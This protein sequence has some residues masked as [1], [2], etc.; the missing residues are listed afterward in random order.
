M[1]RVIMR[2][3]YVV[4]EVCILKDFLEKNMTDISK[5]KRK[6]LLTNGVIEVNGKVQTKYNYPLKVGDKITFRE[7]EIPT[8]L[9]ILY[10]DDDIIVVDKPSGVLTVGTDKHEDNTLYRE[11]SYYV[12]QKK[13]S[14]RIFIVHR[15]DKDTSGIILFCKNQKLKRMF[16]DHWNELV[17]KREYVGI[18]EGVPKQKKG[19]VI[20]YLKENEQFMVYATSPKEGKKAI[21]NYEVIEENGRYAYVRFQLETGR[22]NQIRV[23]CKSLGCPLVGDKKYGAKTNP[24]HRLLLHASMFACI[25]PVTHKKLQ[26]SS[27]IPKNFQKLTK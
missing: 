19:T 5:H 25:H 20:Q 26:F 24:M 27:K 9:N 17:L 2:K 7:K 10:E 12:K 23:A 8:S 1:E 11:V 22:K 4:K 15:L 3:E 6:S 18:T 16:Q 14:N 21:T 13:V